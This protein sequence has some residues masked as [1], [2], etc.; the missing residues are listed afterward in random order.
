MIESVIDTIA[1]NTGMS[2]T[3]VRTMMESGIPMKRFQT[4]EDV[5]SLVLFLA[6]D[7]AGNI[8]GESLNLDGG[9]VRD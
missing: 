6:S 8:S 5:A 2:R 7:L 1:A 4:P 3:D 9:V